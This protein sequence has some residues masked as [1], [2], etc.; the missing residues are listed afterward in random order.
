MPFACEVK[1]QESK[2][3]PMDKLAY[4]TLVDWTGRCIREDKRGAIPPH[5]A[6]ILDRIGMDEQ[7]WLS[8]SQ[9]FETRFKTMAGSWS[10]IKKAAKQLGRCWFQGKKPKTLPT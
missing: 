7:K 8:H 9:H 3:I 2:C 1:S 5:L 4:I 10:S 6:P